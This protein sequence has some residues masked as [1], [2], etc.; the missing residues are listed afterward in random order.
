MFRMH[1]IVKGLIPIVKI[2]RPRRSLKTSVNLVGIDRRTVALFLEPVRGDK[3]LLVLG[4]RCFFL[5]EFLESSAP[6]ACK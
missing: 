1:K 4:G 5:G 6:L 3:I 2:R